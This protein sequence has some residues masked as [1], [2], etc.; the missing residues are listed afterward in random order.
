PDQAPAADKARTLLGGHR[1]LVVEDE[2]L[3]SMDLIAGL[4]E[5]GAEVV[6]SAGTSEEALELIEAGPID[7]ALLDGNLRGRPGG[8]IAAALT[9][10]K[11]PFV[12]VTGYGRES[13]PRAFASTAILSKPFSRVQLVDAA[14]QLVKRPKGAVQLTG[15][16]R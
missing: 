9:R 11:I 13:L 15:R 10:R 2:P 6:G 5:A 7:A 1:F 3:V 16:N 4:Q 12:F 8:D 14:G